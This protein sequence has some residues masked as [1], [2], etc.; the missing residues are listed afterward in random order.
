MRKKDNV[1]YL[2]E[3]DV[4]THIKNLYVQITILRNE[5]AEMRVAIALALC[6][7]VP[8]TLA[9]LMLFAKG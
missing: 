5:A 6:G 2:Y 9:F 3:H 4:P 7:Y 8:V 1:T